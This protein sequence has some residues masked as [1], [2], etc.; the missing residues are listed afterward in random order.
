V[1]DESGASKA[2]EDALAIV[3]DQTSLRSRLGLSFE[4]RRLG[5]DDAIVDLL[6]GRVATDRESEALHT[7]IAAAINSRRWVTAREILAVSSQS[8]Q[9]RDWF[10]RA[11]AIL[12]INTGDAKADEKIARYLKQCPNDV[13]M[14]LARIGIWQR[15]GRDGDIRSLLQGI[16]L[17]ELDGRPEQLIRIAALIVHY[18][19]AASGLH[20]GY[21]VLMDNW[22][23]PQ[24]HLSYQGLIFLNENIG[25]AMSSTNMVGENTVVCLLVEGSERRYRIEKDK[26]AFF[27]DERLD[28]KTSLPRS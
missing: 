20:Y 4:A 14:M 27:E 25:A 1:A 22:N 5:R 11:D 26:H 16:N 6:K 10:K 7:L 23:I 9:E 18:G 12:A 17:A 24:A 21:K 15:A 13:E 28:P 8:L 2:F 3:N 19:A